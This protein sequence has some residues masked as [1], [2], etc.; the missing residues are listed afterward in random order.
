MEQA[1][2]VGSGGGREVEAGFPRRRS[3]DCTAPGHEQKILH[4]PPPPSTFIRRHSVKRVDFRSCRQKCVSFK[5]GEADRHK[6]QFIVSR[7]KNVMSLGA[8]EAQ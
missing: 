3:G 5:V 1:N 8:R 7:F 4:P 6:Q 2:P